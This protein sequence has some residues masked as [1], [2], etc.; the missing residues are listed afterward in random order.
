MDKLKAGGFIIV[1]SF[2]S[3]P[4]IA[5]GFE[6]PEKGVM[7]NPPRHPDESILAG[8]T[9]KTVLFRGSVIGI[10]TILAQYIGLLESPEMGT[11]MAFATL[12]L[13]R[14]VQT[15]AS[16]SNTETIFSLG[17]KSNKYALGAVGICLVMFSFTLLPFMR[18]IF[19]MP[20]SFGII[21]LGISL[22]LAIVA[23]LIMELSKKL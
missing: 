15:F 2:Y 1:T 8:G 17:F 23:S 13:S 9:L 10:V 5:L 20:M 18:G 6:A 14:I 22:G 19:S 7:K 12:T 3:L 4:A 11:A 16:R 21:S